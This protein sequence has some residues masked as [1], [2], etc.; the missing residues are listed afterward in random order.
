MP[1]NKSESANKDIVY[2]GLSYRLMGVLFKVHNKLGS[3]YKEKYY[4]RAIEEELRR[5]GIPFERER[6]IKLYYGNKGIGKYYLDFVID[7]KIA[8]EI[9]AVPF[10]KKDYLDQVL[11]YLYAA[12]LKL[13]IVANFR[14]E[15][16]TYRRLINPKVKIA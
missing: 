16:L 2:P 13:G 5:Q 7:G 14:T 12:N 3:S 9:K 1:A 10:F 11:T 15:R 4:Q 6:E 8:L